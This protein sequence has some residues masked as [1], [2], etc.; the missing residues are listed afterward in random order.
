M[1]PTIPLQFE[2]SIPTSV[3]KLTTDINDKA[4]NA[5]S[6]S[7]V[8]PLNMARVLIP[9][10][11]SGA[12][13]EIKNALHE[14]YLVGQNCDDVLNDMIEGA[15]YYQDFAFLKA[16]LDLQDPYVVSHP[17]SGDA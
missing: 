11:R 15:F 8:P 1:D 4:S 14:I 9:A 10:I 12:T 13:F 6:K 7:Q 16:I 17:N 5:A 3:N 2:L